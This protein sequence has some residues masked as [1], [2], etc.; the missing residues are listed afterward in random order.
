LANILSLDD[1]FRP[2][3]SWEQNTPC[4]PP[5]LAEED[6]DPRRLN[7][8]ATVARLLREQP[9]FARLHLSEAGATEED[10][11]VLGMSFRAQQLQLPIFEYHAWWRET[12]MRLAFAYHRRVIAL[13]QSRRPPDSW[14]FKA[15]AH[16]FHLEAVSSAYPDMRMIVTHRDPAKAIPSAISLLC[17]L[18]PTG[19]KFSAAEFGR[20]HSRHLQIGAER[21]MA[22][23]ARIGE[24]RF[25]DVHHKEFVADSFGTI[26]RIYRFLDKELRPEAL[27]RMKAWHGKNRS[28][29]HGAHR[30]T[31][32]QFGLNATQI[33][34]DFDFYMKHYGVTP[35]TE[36]PLG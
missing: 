27:E 33:R 9:D 30:Y 20:K 1:Q 15:P 4:P 8:E 24:Q 7:A 14:L 23:R 36:S 16:N 35:E 11:E 12:D 34:C 5:V 25:L 32:E 13:L 3:R 26:K 31:P 18:Q 19:Q 10:V 17:A 29:A 2:L 6:V 22:A 28:G 21:A